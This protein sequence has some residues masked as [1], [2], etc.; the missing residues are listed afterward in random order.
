[1]DPQLWAVYPIVDSDWLSMSPKL[2]V[3][4]H[5]HNWVCNIADTCQAKPVRG[6]WNGC[7]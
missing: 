3:S 2:K 5:L 7:K 1:M 6:N 4:H